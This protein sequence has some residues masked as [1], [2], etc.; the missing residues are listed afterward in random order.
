MMA[1]VQLKVNGRIYV[2]FSTLRVYAIC[3]RR[4]Y[5][6]APVLVFSGFPIVLNLVSELFSL[7]HLPDMTQADLVAAS[8][9]LGARRIGAHI[10]LSSHLN[11]PS[12]ALYHVRCAVALFPHFN[13]SELM[14]GQM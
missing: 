4:W 5:L 3:G 1:P 2:V 8:L 9:P 12:E 10:R 13:S 7:P 6:A 11:S 14:T